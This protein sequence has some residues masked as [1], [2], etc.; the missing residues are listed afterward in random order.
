MLGK[1][2]HVTKKF[3]TLARFGLFGVFL[4]FAEIKGAVSCASE[5][6]S[7]VWF[8]APAAV[9]LDDYVTPSNSRR[10]KVSNLLP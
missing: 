4:H 8:Y 5:E 10:Q 1:H 6:N 3:I 9:I 7:G 2:R